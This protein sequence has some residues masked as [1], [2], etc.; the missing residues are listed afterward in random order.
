VLKPAGE[1]NQARIVVRGARIEHWLNGSLIVTANVGD[2]EWQK[3][4]AESK[5]SDAADFGT[6]RMGRIM[7]TDHGSDVAYRK[8]VFQALKENN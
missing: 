7:L 2:E 8:F 3:R 1:W 5:F 6:N 4:I